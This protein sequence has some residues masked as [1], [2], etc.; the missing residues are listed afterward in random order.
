MGRQ[1]SA[2]AYIRPP[3]EHQLKQFLG[4]NWSVAIGG[5]QSVDDNWLVTI[6]WWQLVGD[7][8]LMTNGDQL[9]GAN[10]LMTI[11]WRHWLA[12]ICWWK[13]VGDNWWVATG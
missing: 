13:L 1:G 8:W 5:R 12:T 9:A 7:N 10:Q 2:A 6:S 3:G 11:G 4:G